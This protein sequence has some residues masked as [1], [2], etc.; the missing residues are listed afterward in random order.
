MRAVYPAFDPDRVC[1][2][3][4]IGNAHERKAGIAIIEDDADLFLDPFAGTS[5]QDVARAPA[6]NVLDAFAALVEELE[7]I[8]ALAVREPE[9]LAGFEIR[10]R[11]GGAALPHDDAAAQ[12]RIELQAD[13]SVTHR[14]RRLGREGKART[15]AAQTGTRN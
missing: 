12:L 3:L 15:A 4:A 14:R 7:A 2:H 11:L 6:V 1:A 8:D 13:N 5:T 9:R 10:E